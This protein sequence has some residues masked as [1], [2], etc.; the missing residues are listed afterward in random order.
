MFGNL[1][2]LVCLV[3]LLYAASVSAAN[4]F[5]QEKDKSPKE[6][7]RRERPPT[8]GPKPPGFFN[9]SASDTMER[10]VPVDPNVAIKLCVSEG[11]LKIN[12]WRRDEVRIF[13]RNGR[14]F[15]MKPLEKSAE[16]GKVNWLWVAHAPGTPGRAV[17]ECLLGENIE[18]DAPVGASFDLTGRDTR[19]SIDSVKKVKVRIAEG[20]IMLRNIAGGITANTNQ[21]DVMVDNSA[22][23]IQ[24]ES[25]TGNIV[26]IDVKPGQIGELLRAKTNS[27]AISLQRVEHRQIDANSISGSLLFDG[28]FLTGG[29]YNFRTSNGSIKLAIPAASSCTF[30]FIY[31]VGQ[32]E[33]E[34]PMTIISQSDLPR[35]KTVVAKMGAG[36]ASVSLTTSTGSIGIRKAAAGGKP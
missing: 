21:G 35:L 33:S 10:A 19:M 1:K 32:F 8:P 5:G 30:K 9:E 18:I 28:R 16:S 2:N 20:V 11:N 17:S 12:G 3:L 26:A 34:M 4:V 31:G 7:P 13:V 24:L 23:A 6:P 15:Q 27:G 14:R 25:T 36:D 29:I 22:G